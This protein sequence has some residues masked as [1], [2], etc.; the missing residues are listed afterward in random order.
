MEHFLQ[1][2]LYHWSRWS[3][4]AWWLIWCVNVTCPQGAQ[5]LLRLK[6]ILGVFVRMSLGEIS[7]WRKTEWSI[8]SSLMWV[9]LIN[10]PGSPACQLQ[11]FR[12]SVSITCE[13]IPYSKYIYSS[14]STTHTYVVHTV[15]KN[16]LANI[17]N[18]VSIHGSGRSPGVGNGNPLQY[19]CWEDPMDRGSRH[20]T[21]RGIAKSWTWLSTC[22][23]V[24]ILLVLFLWRILTHTESE[25]HNVTSENE[26]EMIHCKSCSW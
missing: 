18:A 6:I 24:Y 19:S 13:P 25:I 7:I 26:K 16:L 21:A 23:Y 17:E 20:A 8:F 14:Y 9:G 11:I 12:L 1:I 15:V 10:S 22:A 3:W 4:M 5:A 2:F